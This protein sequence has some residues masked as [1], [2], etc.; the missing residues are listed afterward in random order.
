[1]LIDPVSKQWCTVMYTVFRSK[2]LKLVQYLVL[3]PKKNKSLRG[4]T[5]VCY[6]SGK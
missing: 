4:W 6:S 5:M 1:M 3:S 2:L